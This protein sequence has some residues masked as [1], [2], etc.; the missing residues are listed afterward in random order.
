MSS[1]PQEDML[2][3]PQEDML[4]RCLIS[5]EIGVVQNHHDLVDDAHSGPCRTL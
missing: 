5:L 4:W 3:L 1:L 2:S